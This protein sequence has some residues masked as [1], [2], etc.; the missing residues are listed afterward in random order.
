VTPEFSH[1][2]KMD[3][4]GSRPETIVLRAKPEERKALAKRFDLLSLDRL[5]ASLNVRRDGADML[6]EGRMTATR[7]KRLN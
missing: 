1:S 6:V 3:Q 7:T 2:I 4:L 5:E